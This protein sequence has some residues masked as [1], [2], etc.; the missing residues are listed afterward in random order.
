M[1][2]FTGKTRITLFLDDIVIHHFRALSGIPGKGYQEIINGALRAHLDVDKEPLTAEVVR[3]ML[4]ED[5]S[6]HG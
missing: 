3:R 1:V 5:L 6:H 2:P 4:R